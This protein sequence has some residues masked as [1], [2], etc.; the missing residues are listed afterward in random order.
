MGNL[1]DYHDIVFLEFFIN[2]HENLNN[3]FNICSF[4]LNKHHD[5]LIIPGSIYLYSEKI[6]VQ[7]ELENAIQNIEFS[8]INKDN[9][10]TLNTIKTVLLKDFVCLKN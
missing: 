5:D 7:D 8:I 3:L 6:D 1:K 9:N 2:R 10:T 4:Y